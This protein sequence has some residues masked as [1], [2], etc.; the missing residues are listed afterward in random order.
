MATVRNSGP[1]PTPDRRSFGIAA[2][3]CV[4]SAPLLAAVFFASIAVA[5]TSALAIDLDDLP[6]VTPPKP[7]ANP[8]KCIISDEAAFRWIASNPL[9]A[10]LNKAH[11]DIAKQWDNLPATSFGHAKSKNLASTQTKAAS[12]L[13][14]QR[15]DLWSMALTIAGQRIPACDIC[16]SANNWGKLYWISFRLGNFDDTIGDFKLADLTQAQVDSNKV[17]SKV[18]DYIDTYK[19]QQAAPGR[20]VG[21]T[22]DQNNQLNLQCFNEIKRANRENTTPKAALCNKEYLGAW[23]TN[24]ATSIK[25]LLK[26]ADQANPSSPKMSTR[27]KADLECKPKGIFS[28]KRYVIQ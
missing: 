15:A 6:S 9:T 22:P 21:N 16:H 25:K 14:S 8:N 3:R 18:D 20:P 28:Y 19:L 13:K 2:R 11:D 24:K 12:L 27:V 7:P 10:A 5:A 23:L 26:T 1:F 17:S 4:K